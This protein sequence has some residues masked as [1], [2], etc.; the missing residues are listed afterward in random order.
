MRKTGLNFGAKVSSHPDP[1]AAAGAGGNNN[2]VLGT[3]SPIYDQT[4]GTKLSSCT[5]RNKTDRS[6]LCEHRRSRSS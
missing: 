2:G 5:L 1:K 4:D 6:G 3:G